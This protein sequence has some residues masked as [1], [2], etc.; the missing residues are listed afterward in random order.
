MMFLLTGANEIVT[1]F[2]QIADEIIPL[3]VVK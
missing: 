2:K 1:T 3:R